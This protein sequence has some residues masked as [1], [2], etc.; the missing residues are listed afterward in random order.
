M[1]QVLEHLPPMEE[2]MMQL[3]APASSLVYSQQ[4]QPFWKRT[5]G[6]KISFFLFLLPSLLLCLSNN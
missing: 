5:S 3:P 6:W 1:A 2:N 4:L